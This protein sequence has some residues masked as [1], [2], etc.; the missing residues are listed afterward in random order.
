MNTQEQPSSYSEDTQ[1]S[2]LL[3]EGNSAAVEL[4]CSTYTPRVRLYVMSR[5]SDCHSDEHDDLTQ[6][7]IIAALKGIRS[8]RGKSSLLTWV[9]SITHH[10]VSDAI[11]ARIK[12]RQREVVFSDV[13]PDE[14]TEWDIPDSDLSHEPEA[15]ALLNQLR[16]RVR[17]TVT[18]LKPEHQE[19]L[20]LR[21]VEELA[22]ADIAL[23]LGLNKRKVE[24]WLT[25]ARAA[26][27]RGIGTDSDF[28][29]LAT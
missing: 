19:V 27:R 24:Y 17:S 8:Y 15:A 7:I 10:K 18:T 14:N 13:M 16:G 5:M 26:F 3:A 4:F 9:L 22:V 25:E 2:R 12:R 21:Y 28:G 29:E 23:V 11:K 20:I 6:I 1:L